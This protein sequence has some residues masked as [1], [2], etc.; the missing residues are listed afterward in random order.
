MASASLVAFAGPAAAADG[1]TGALTAGTHYA[2]DVAW[3]EDDNGWGPV[4]LDHNNGARAV[5]DPDRGPISIRGTKYAK[6]LGVHAPSSIVYDVGHRCTQLLG[7]V[8]ID[9][10]QSPKGRVD[11]VVVLDDA[12][13]FRVARK[14]TDSAAPLNVDLRGVGKVELRVEAGPEGP[15]NDHADWADLRFVCSDTFEAPPLRLTPKGVDLAH[16]APGSAVS[17]VVDGA[18]PLAQV[19]VRFGDAE[20]HATADHAGRAIVSWVVPSDAPAG[21]LAVT[22]SAPAKFGATARGSLEARVVAVSGR[23]HFVDCSAPTPG[24]GGE[25]SPLSSIDQLNAVASFGPGDSVRFR[26]GVECHGT[27]APKGSGADV[28][29]IVVS[30]Y[31]PGNEPATVNGDGALAAL[32]F[33][34]VSHWT[35]RGMRVVNPG[36]PTVRRTGILYETT[37][38]VARSGVVITDNL[39]EDVGGATKKD[40]PDMQPYVQS[41]AIVV[42]GDGKGP[43]HGVTITGNRVKDAGGGAIKISAPDTSTDRNTAV[44]IAHNDLRDI[45][46]DAVVVHNS[47]APLIE[48]NVAIGLGQG[49]YPFRGGNFAG[50]WPFNSDDPTFQFNVVGNSSWSKY[51]ST[52]WD[53]DIK[54]TGTCLFQY[55]YSFGNSGGF[56]LNCVGGCSGG[57]TKT[58]VVLRYNIAQDDCRLAGASSGTGK[59]LV[60]NNTF[61]C[62]TRPFEDDMKGPRE[63]T[64]NIVVSPGGSLRTSGAVYSHNAYWGGITPP[65]GE[66]GAVL[67][68]P[69]LVALGSGQTSRDLPGYRLRAGSPLL[70]AGAQVA[71]AEVVGPAERDFF[72]API[73]ATP[74]IGADQGPGVAPEAPTF[75]QAVNVTSVAGAG[76]RRNAAITTDFRA[77]SR[78]ALAAAGLDTG[79]KATAFGAQ[80]DW[81]PRPVGTPDS[82][83]AAGQTIALSGEG[84]SLL[85]VGFST[86][87]AKPRTATVTYQDGTSQE[88]TIDLPLWDAG[89]VSRDDVATL[90]VARQHLIRSTAFLPSDHGPVDDSR[91]VDGD[92]AVFAQ[93]IPLTGRALASLTLP[94]GSP[95]VGEGVTLFALALNDAPTNDAPTSGADPDAV[96][97]T[98]TPSAT[99]V[100]P[101]PTPNAVAPTPTPTPNAVAPTPTPTPN[102]VAPTPTPSATAAPTVAPTPTPA[103]SA[104]AAAQPTPSRARPGVP[105]GARPTRPSASPSPSPSPSAAS[106]RAS[107]GPRDRLAATGSD[108]L[109]LGAVAAALLT[110]TGAGLWLAARRRRSDPE[111]Q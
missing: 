25:A 79:A 74:N 98:P 39:V 102:A 105:A 111:G 29:P 53:C 62:T 19:T 66:T 8:G 81:H 51:D 88:V 56:Y 37:D 61:V 63:F 52:A 20:A 2:S 86:G 28:A 90:A 45:G 21:A 87:E 72:G 22:A 89:R 31:G 80:V 75:E 47:A 91:L 57:A 78:E 27:F 71:G 50:M 107:V 99:A 17:I 69:G 13:A 76:N 36:E 7:E 55:N 26:R 4:E 108:A 40:A 23:A 59:H 9:D 1:P 34:N 14:G 92:A 30:P 83:K 54:N 94:E 68:D 109:L 18:T 70:G 3:V 101:T 10:S 84:R 46:G 104:S 93:R 77:F 15:G 103:P 48:H 43:F 100:T 41:G 5:P 44:H 96:T 24:D 106:S 82:V 32:R 60:Y 58:D 95:V 65:A 12:E 6:G 16:L 64:N 67:G 110:L 85:V 97:P 49:K 11:F 38:G 42:R 33:T 35:V 73:P